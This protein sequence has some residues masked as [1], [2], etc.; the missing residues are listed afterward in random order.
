M[1]YEAISL[2]PPILAANSGSLF[3][4]TVTDGVAGTTTKGETEHSRSS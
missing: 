1:L 4:E 3:A 2:I